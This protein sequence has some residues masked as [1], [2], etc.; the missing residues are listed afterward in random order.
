MVENNNQEPVVVQIPDM[1][2]AK[3]AKVSLTPEDDVMSF[4]HNWA[5]SRG[6]SDAGQRNFG[7]DVPVSPEQNSKGLRGYAYWIQVPPDTKGD[8]DVVV[9]PFTGAS[10]ISLRLS[11]PF[12]NPFEIIPQGWQNLSRFIETKQL[13]VACCAPGDCLE[14]VIGEGEEADML[15]YIKLAETDSSPR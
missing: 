4:M 9:E 15:I 8:Q 5:K 10:Y 14:E 1:S 12:R 11:K 13:K 3:C 7:F 6:L 2:L